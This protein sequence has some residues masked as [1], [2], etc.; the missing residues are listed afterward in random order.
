MTALTFP[1]D[2]FPALPSITVDLPDDW[3]PI[4]VPGTIAAAAAPDVP[5][6]FRPNVVVSVTRF[7]ADYSLDLAAQ[8]VAD[9]FAGL[10]QAHELGRDRITVDGLEWAHIESTFID[11]RVGTLVQAA[12]LAVVPN[13]PCADLVQVT[14]SVT[15]AQA[16]DGVLDTLRDIQRSARAARA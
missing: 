7:G 13:G 8:V 12:H 2:A 14:G 11:P 9:K 10:E 15:A 4:S 5:G 16:K 1:S 3:S 6:E